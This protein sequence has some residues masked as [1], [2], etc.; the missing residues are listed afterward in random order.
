MSL[1]VAWLSA[2]FQNFQF[3]A[4]ADP[5][6]FSSVVTFEDLSGYTEFHAPL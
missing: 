4:S 1:N 3:P 6:N 5:S 2:V